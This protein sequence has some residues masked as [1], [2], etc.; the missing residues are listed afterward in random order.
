MQVSKFLDSDMTVITNADE[1]R[2]DLQSGASWRLTYVYFTLNK[3]EC[4][5]TW[6]FALK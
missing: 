5:F 6:Y 4:R 2:A 1:V 3:C